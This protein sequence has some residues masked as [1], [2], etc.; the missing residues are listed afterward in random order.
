M[1]DIK[2]LTDL[3]EILENAPEINIHN[4]DINDVEVLNSAMI[5]AYNLVLEIIK[6]EIE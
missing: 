1:V 4:F 6:E 3:E 2:K 5:E